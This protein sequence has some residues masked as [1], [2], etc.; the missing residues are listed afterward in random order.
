MQIMGVF[1][2]SNEINLKKKSDLIHSK[3]MGLKLNSGGSLTHLKTDIPDEYNE[4][5]TQYYQYERSEKYIVKIKVYV[6]KVKITVFFGI[7]PPVVKVDSPVVFSD[8][9]KAVNYIESF[10]N[11]M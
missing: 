5:Y 11:S 1:E 4:E 2:M 3:I 7:A 8:I 9:E 6:D 10:L